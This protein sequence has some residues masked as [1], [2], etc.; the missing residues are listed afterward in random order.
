MARQE[1][2]IAYL[3]LSGILGGN[4]AKAMSHQSAWFS[5]GINLPSLVPMESGQTGTVTCWHP[6]GWRLNGRGFSTGSANPHGW[7]QIRLPVVSQ[8]Y[9]DSCSGW[10]A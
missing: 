5:A 9:R 1:N 4:P 7:N 3:R 10:M 6:R 8:P 2:V